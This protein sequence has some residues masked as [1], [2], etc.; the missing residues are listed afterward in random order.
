LNIHKNIIHNPIRKEKMSETVPQSNSFEVLSDEP[1]PLNTAAIEPV[2]EKKTRER[3][4]GKVFGMGDFQTVDQTEIK[5]SAVINSTDH[6]L[7][8]AQEAINVLC[9]RAKKT[10]EYR[11]SKMVS[12]T[13]SMN[14]VGPIFKDEFYVRLN[15]TKWAIITETILKSGKVEIDGIDYVLDPQNAIRTWDVI[16]GPSDRPTLFKDKKILSLGEKLQAIVQEDTHKDMIKEGRL[17]ADDPYTPTVWLFLA[18]KQSYRG[19]QE[20]CRFINMCW[21]SNG[22]TADRL[23]PVSEYCTRRT[24]PRERKQNQFREKRQDNAHLST[25][26]QKDNRPR[27]DTK[28]RQA[29]QNR[30]PR[31][32]KKE[33]TV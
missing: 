33:N 5:L 1:T 18:Y 24:Q 8:L 12:G 25:T 28:S 23:M 19:R 6:Y 21:D 7:E 30:P 29:R 2:L 3:R 13:T 26:Q 22:T 15:P 10:I 31:P 20:P 17:K 32:E 11:L 16:A 27:Y 4:N 14:I 9:N